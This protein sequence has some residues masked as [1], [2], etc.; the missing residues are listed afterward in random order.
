MP[1]RCKETIIRKALFVLIIIPSLL[2]SQQRDSIKTEKALKVVPLLTST[3]LLGWGFGVSTS[4]LYKGDQSKVSKSQLNVGGQY[5]STKSSTIFIKNNLWLKDNSY[6]S[7]TNIG[8][9]DINNEFQD[10][11]FGDVRYKVN[12][13]LAAEILMFRIANH[14]YIGTPLSYKKLTYTP[15]NENG[16]E[17]I[18]KNGI[19]DENTGGFG[20]MASYDS[21]KNKFFPSNS[22]W[23]T[24]SINNNPEWLGAVDNYYS[25]VIDARYYAKGFRIN[26]VWAWQFYGQY[27]SDKTPDSGLPSLSG[28]SLLRGYPSGQ[29]KAKY[30]TGAQTEYRYTI[31]NSRFR[32][33][34]FFG[35][36]NL[37]GGSY[38]LD[39]NS[40]NNDGWYTAQG[41]GIRYM[42]QQVTGV[43]LGLDAVYSS[44]GQVSFYLKLNQAF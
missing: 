3:P 7:S 23:V 19:R 28:K 8:F 35:L 24:T 40:R 21:R 11:V 2:F 12:S 30:L 4:Y 5:S 44:E 41:A 13:L 9:S 31:D 15:N 43:D 1:R 14:I 18:K 20:F 32:F 27:S 34:G 22:A 39:G 38:G 33:L 26:D 29:F 17:F 10:D 16:E 37:S 25:F 42:L 6:L 36:A